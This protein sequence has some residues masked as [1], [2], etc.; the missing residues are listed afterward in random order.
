[1][2][3]KEGARNH[4][5]FGGLALAALAHEA[6]T[7]GRTPAEGYTTAFIGVSLGAEAMLTRCTP[8]VRLPAIATMGAP[9]SSIV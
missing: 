6:T 1:M 5:V 3:V 7:S 4:A 2:T 8:P 9:P